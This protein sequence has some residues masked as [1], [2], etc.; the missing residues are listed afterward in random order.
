MAKKSK[1]KLVATSHV[2]VATS[3]EEESELASGEVEVDQERVQVN[4]ASLPEMKHAIGKLPDNRLCANT[5]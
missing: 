1:S 5:N 3:E 2:K 4:N